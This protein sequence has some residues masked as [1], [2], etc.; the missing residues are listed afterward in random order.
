[1][2][3]YITSLVARH[4]YRS[5][6][7]LR[8]PSGCRSAGA[9][10]IRWQ[11]NCKVQT[12]LSFSKL[13]GRLPYAYTRLCGISLICASALP[14]LGQNHHPAG[15]DTRAVLAIRAQ[16]YFSEHRH[17]AAAEA[18]EELASFLPK[19]VPVFN[20]LSVYELRLGLY[21]GAT[22]A[23]RTALKLQPGSPPVLINLGL[24]LF[25]SGGF[26]DAVP[27]LREALEADPSSFQAE[28]L[29]DLSLYAAKEFAQASRTFERISLVSPNHTTVQYLLG[30]SYLLSS[31][32]R[33]LLVYFRALIKR[34]PNSVA[35]HVLMGEAYDGLDRTAKAIDEFEA[36]LAVSPA[37]PGLRFDLGY[38]FWKER[39][40]DNA[41]VEFE[42]N[43]KRWL[44]GKIESL[45]G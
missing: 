36:A 11:V 43:Q 12:L 1:M 30:Q 9:V 8:P 15:R 42:R 34:S 19:S 38:L 3:A 16:T 18:Y 10:S 5:A 14:L 23:F 27:P 25:K 37:Q 33:E 22:R 21:S 17:R 31:Q 29:L 20:N 26:K 32:Y 45:S 40:F 7:M 4:S 41:A 24:A 13:T 35:A 28:A 6:K 2:G 44:G 39:R